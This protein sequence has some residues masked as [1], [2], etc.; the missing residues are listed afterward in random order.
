MGCNMTSWS[1]TSLAPVSVSQE[2]NDTVNDMF[3]FVRSR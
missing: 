2:D 1:V 3:A